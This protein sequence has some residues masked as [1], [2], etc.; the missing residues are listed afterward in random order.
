MFWRG[1]LR[2]TCNKCPLIQ[3]STLVLGPDMSQVYN[4]SVGKSDQRAKR[5]PGSWNG[6]HVKSPENTHHEEPVANATLRLSSGRMAEDGLS[7]GQG[8]SD[9]SRIRKCPGQVCFN[10]ALCGAGPSWA[11]NPEQTP[12][13]GLYVLYFQMRLHLKKC[14][15]G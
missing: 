12:S 9:W 2:D 8:G 6:Q 13:Y 10:W 14:F 15:L 3:V 4:H 5:R 1:L 11:P 7:Q